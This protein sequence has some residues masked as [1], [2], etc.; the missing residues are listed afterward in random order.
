MFLNSEDYFDNN[1]NHFSGPDLVW[2]THTSEFSPP[3]RYYQYLEQGEA[4]PDKQ[5]ICVQEVMC[6]ILRGGLL[7][8]K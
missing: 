3:T 5:H 4:V 6:P 2:D 7:Q 1:K 8:Q